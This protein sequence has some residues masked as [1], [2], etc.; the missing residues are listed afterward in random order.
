M[1]PLEI[2]PVAFRLVAEC[3]THLRYRVWSGWYIQ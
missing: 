1:T 2:E 3:L